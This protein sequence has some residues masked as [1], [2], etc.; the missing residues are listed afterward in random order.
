[1]LLVEKGNE[2][3]VK[4]RLIKCIVGEERDCALNREGEPLGKRS[5]SQDLK[6]VRGEPGG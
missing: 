3:K 2:E 1:M 4:Q 5:W 6:E